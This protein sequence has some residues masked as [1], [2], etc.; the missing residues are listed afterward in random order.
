MQLQD[1][2]PASIGEAITLVNEAINLLPPLHPDLVCFLQYLGSLLFNMFDYTYDS[3]YLEST[4][5]SFCK[6]V[7]LSSASA[8]LRFA[9]ARSWAHHADVH[10]HP[11][12]LEAYQHAVELLPRL[13]TL[14][15]TLQAQQEILASRSD[16]LACNVAA[17]T[18]RSGEFDKAVKFLEQGWTMFWS[19]ALWLRTPLDSLSIEALKLAE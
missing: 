18:I 10:T 2:H 9:A 12:A 3:N 1:N 17:C 13:A 8:L 5:D 16:G 19:Q 7:N 14:G 4:V 15:H 11:S 6:A